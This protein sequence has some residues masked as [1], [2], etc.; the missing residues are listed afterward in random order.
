MA[1]IYTN[2]LIENHLITNLFA[3]FAEEKQNQ[4]DILDNATK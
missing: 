4:L 2:C 1:T 3:N